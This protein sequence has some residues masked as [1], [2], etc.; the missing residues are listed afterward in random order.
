[1][2]KTNDSIQDRIRQKIFRERPYSIFVER[3]TDKSLV[4]QKTSAPE[5]IED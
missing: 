1:M 3:A 2:M 5:L 4:W